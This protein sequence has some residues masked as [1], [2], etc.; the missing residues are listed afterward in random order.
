MIGHARGDGLALLLFPLL[1]LLFVYS[2]IQVV[3]LNANCSHCYQPPPAPLS[4][5]LRYVSSLCHL[6]SILLQYIRLD[7]IFSLPRYL[8]KVINEFSSFSL[9]LFLSSDH[10]SI[11]FLPKSTNTLPTATFPVSGRHTLISGFNVCFGASA[12]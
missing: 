10:Y 5:S 2:K 4:C 12:G 3:P 7:F 1:F 6:C 11:F 8:T 9:S